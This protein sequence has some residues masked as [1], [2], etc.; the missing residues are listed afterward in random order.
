MNQCIACK[1]NDSY[2]RCPTETISGLSFCGRHVRSKSARIWHVVNNLDDKITKISKV[3]RGY[4]VRRLLKLAGPGVLK[5]SMCHNDEELV[6][7]ETKDRLYP[8]DY[9]SF[10]EDEKV[11]WFDIRSIIS[12]LNSSLIPLNPYTRTP[13]S[14]ETRQR[15]RHLYRYRV[16]YRKPIYHNHPANKSHSELLDFQWMRIC[17]HLAENGFEDVHPNHFLTLDRKHLYTLLV[18]ITR[19]MKAL[20]T[21][22]PKSSKRY[23]YYAILKREQEYFNSFQSPFL[24]FANLFLML[25]NDSV[26]PYNLCFLLMS[27]LHRL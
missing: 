14:I 4:A 10:K 13:L 20:T 23:R 18:F 12:C 19:D 11:W 3:W 8:L 15:L 17:Q 25:L 2:E 26:E 24:H 7:F 9:F 6:T 27:A 22:H 16:Y 1:N 21:E 5:R